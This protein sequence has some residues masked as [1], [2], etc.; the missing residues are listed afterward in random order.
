MRAKIAHIPNCLLASLLIAY[1]HLDDHANETI[2]ERTNESTDHR[3]NDAKPINDLGQIISQPIGPIDTSDRHQKGPELPPGAATFR[4]LRAR[5][6]GTQIRGEY[7]L[8]N[9]IE[10]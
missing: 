9:Y 8:I 5:S 7:C 3:T 10:L 2:N 4:R 6:Q 1:N